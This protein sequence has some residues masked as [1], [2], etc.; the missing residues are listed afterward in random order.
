MT[1]GCCHSGRAPHGL[2]SGHAYTLL[3]VKDIYKDGAK[4]TTL[5]KLRNPWASER[6]DGPWSDNDHRWT[7]DF[8]K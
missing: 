7:D 1:A 6:Y 2:V 4:Y 3:D 5:A 8:R